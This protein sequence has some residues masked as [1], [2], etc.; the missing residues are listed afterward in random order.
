MQCTYHIHPYQPSSHLKI[1]KNKIIYR[2]TVII[3]LHAVSLYTL[4]NCYAYLYLLKNLLN[5]DQNFTCWKT[6]T[7]LHKLNTLFTAGSH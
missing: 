2:E 1:N 5:Q 4:I 6:F 7:Y 3:S